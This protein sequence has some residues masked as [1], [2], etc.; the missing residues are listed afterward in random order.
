MLPKNEIYLDWNATA[1]PAPEV[2]AAML[3]V[4]TDCWG[5]PASVHAVG[6]RARS[7]VESCR[8]VA[9]ELLQV[10]PRD[11]LFTSGGTE[12]NNLALSSAIG[13]VT[14]R[15]E[16]PSVTRV[17]EWMQAAGRPVVWLS[18]APS[19]AIEP[20]DV[21]VALCHV[22][23]GSTVALAAVNHETGVVQPILEVLELARAREARVH[24]DAVQAI[25]KIER[26]WFLGADSLTVAAHKIR[27]PKGIGLLAWRGQPPQPLLRGGA[28]ERG[29]R[30]GTQDATLAAG[31]RVA[32]N[33]AHSGPSRYA[34]LEALRDRLEAELAECSEING[35]GSRAPHISNL[36]FGGW[37]ADE[38][39]AALDLDGVFVSSGSACSAGTAEA[40]PVITAMSGEGRALRSVRFSLGETT[41]HSELDVA[42]GC[43]LNHVAPTAKNL[44]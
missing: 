35:K 1:P 3:E 6:R 2:L 37:R 4:Q 9:G 23:V 12:A 40:S 30:P 31:F 38:L 32:L 14:S 10:H 22:P 42:I 36:A 44:K 41:T 34:A 13:L 5:N 28:Q 8:E 39:V 26:S 18:V 24:V 25:G 43:V 21:N 29:L 11:V 7:V 16:H 17:G 19:G 15:L 27:G 20:E 33:R